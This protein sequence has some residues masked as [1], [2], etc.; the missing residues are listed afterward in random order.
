MVKVF[1]GGAVKHEQC[2]DGG[3]NESVSWLFWSTL[4]KVYY[5][6]SCLHF[7]GIEKEPLCM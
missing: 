6:Q 3:M 2:K 5:K 4:N 1:K 7:T